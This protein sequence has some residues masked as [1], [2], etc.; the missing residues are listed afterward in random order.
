MV[1]GAVWPDWIHEALL[2]IQAQ[3]GDPISLATVAR[4]VGVHRA[5][6]AAGFRRYVGRSVGE[7]IRDVRVRHALDALCH[8]HRP[9]SEIA[10]LCGF[11]DQSH[12]GRVVKGTTG[13]TPAQIR[14]RRYSTR[15]QIRSAE[16]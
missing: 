7:Q 3:Y 16:M 15:S 2:T 4:K 13:L 5:T 8:S 6:L 14:A 10:F 9:I 11:C 1:G 12:L